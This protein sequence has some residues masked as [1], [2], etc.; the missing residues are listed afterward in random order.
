MHRFAVYAASC[1]VLWVMWAWFA[2]QIL[3]RTYWA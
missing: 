2:L 3:E 1:V